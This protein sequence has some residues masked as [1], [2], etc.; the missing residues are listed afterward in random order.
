[1]ACG[2][3]HEAAWTCN[4]AE[5]INRRASTIG[6]IVGGKYICKAGACIIAK[7]R[8]VNCQRWYRAVGSH[9]WRIIININ[10][11][12]SVGGV[13]INIGYGVVKGEWRIV[14][15]IAR[16]MR[17]RR[18]LRHGVSARAAVQRNRQNSRSSLLDK[19]RTI[20]P[21]N[22]AEPVRCT[23][24]LVR[25]GQCAIAARTGQSSRCV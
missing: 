11:Q 25:K 18:I 19:D 1:M 6:T 15:I 9:N 12:R 10:D 16:C 2:C 4:N 8:L 21:C 23:R 14:F 7:N 22:I 17:D 5:C 13:T 20:G 3:I 24:Q